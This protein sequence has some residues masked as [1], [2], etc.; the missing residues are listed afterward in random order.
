MYLYHEFAIPLTSLKPEFISRPSDKVVKRGENITFHCNVYGIPIPQ[1]KWLHKNR[2]L[3]SD[4]GHKVVAPYDLFIEN[5]KSR[6]AGEY[7]CQA[8][9]SKGTA[10]A[11]AEL[12]VNSPTSSQ[13]QNF[14]AIPVGS[15]SFLLKWEKPNTSDGLLIGYNITYGYRHSSSMRE[16]KNVINI[17][18]YI[19]QI[20]LNDLKSN[21]DYHFSIISIV[22]KGKLSQQQ[23]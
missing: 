10:S 11:S 21:T 13:I 16:V 4:Y 20:R 3:K 19:T 1:I 12:F 18:P 9:N 2:E 8:S 6:D 5:V 17:R 14:V 15:T 23:P 22:I 7:T